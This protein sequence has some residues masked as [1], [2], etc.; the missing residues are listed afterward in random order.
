MQIARYQPVG[1]ATEEAKSVQFLI[2]SWAMFFHNQQSQLER[3]PN[4]LGARRREFPRRDHFHD[5]NDVDFTQDIPKS[6]AGRCKSRLTSGMSNEMLS[7]HLERRKWRLFTFAKFILHRTMT[8]KRFPRQL[9]SDLPLRS[10]LYD[11]SISSYRRSKFP[12]CNVA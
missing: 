7:K 10:C 2:S 6:L 3:D 9:R 1:K 5:T 4:A 8:S 12:L 11:A